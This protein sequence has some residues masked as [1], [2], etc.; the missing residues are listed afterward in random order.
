M[1]NLDTGYFPDLSTLSLKCLSDY[2]SELTTLLNSFEAN[3]KPAKEITRTLLSNLKNTG[4]STGEKS[5]NQLE[6]AWVSAL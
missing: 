3:Q 4:I 6:G 5:E 1:E 2:D